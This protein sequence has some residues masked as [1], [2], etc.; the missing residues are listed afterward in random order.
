MHSGTGLGLS[1]VQAIANAHNGKVS[2]TIKDDSY[3]QVSVE[4][5]MAR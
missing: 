2:I 5:M 4:L 3:F 1:I